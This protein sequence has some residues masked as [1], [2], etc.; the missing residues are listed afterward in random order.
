M[1]GVAVLRERWSEKT[2]VTGLSLCEALGV[3][4]SSAMTVWQAICVHY[5]A[6]AVSTTSRSRSTSLRRAA[7][8]LSARK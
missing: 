8:P 2:A 5:F 4:R 1:G 7:L 6:G 3:L